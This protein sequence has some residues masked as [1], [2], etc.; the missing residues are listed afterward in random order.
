M[1]AI[2]RAP[3]EG[4][5]PRAS[6][7]RRIVAFAIDVIVV[8]A[9]VFLFA[10]ALA[11]V[12]GPAVRLD[13]AAPDPAGRVVVAFGPLL[14][15]TLMAVAVS[16]L[17]FAGSWSAARAT[18]AQRLLG[19]EVASSS[20]GT[21]PSPTA[22]LIRWIVLFPPFGLVAVILAD[23]RGAGTVLALL[24]LGWALTLLIS[25]LRNPRGRGLHDRVAGTEVRHAMPSV[26]D[27]TGIL[28]DD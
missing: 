3:L 6:L 12:T 1:T 2:D 4:R 15:R 14:V 11:A 22:A 20:T 10:I 9:L 21:E 23:V 26:L 17:Y 28:A 18:P 13:L 24:G 25:T 16:A 27:R 19:L 8:S 5:H 7:R